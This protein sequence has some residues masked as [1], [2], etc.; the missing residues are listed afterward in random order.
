MRQHEVEENRA[1]RIS[2]RTG[3]LV[4]LNDIHALTRPETCNDCNQFH[5]RHT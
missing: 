4:D 5:S 3:D 2:V 1:C